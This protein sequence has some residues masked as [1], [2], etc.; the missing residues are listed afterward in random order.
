MQRTN[1][2]LSIC[3][4]QK[5]ECSYTKFIRPAGLQD[6]IIE[7]SNIF[8]WRCGRHLLCRGIMDPINVLCHTSY[9]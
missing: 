3:C 4:V 1:V 2:I 5:Y 7:S 8:R 6:E 9:I